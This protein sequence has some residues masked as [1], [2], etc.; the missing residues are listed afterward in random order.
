[1]ISL[2]N[3]SVHFGGKPLFEDVSFII[4]RRDRIGLTGLNGAGK[5]TLMRIIK[6]QMAP[7]T[8]QVSVPAASTI[9]YLPQELKLTSRKK[10]IDETVEAFAELKELEKKISH[11]NQVLGHPETG[12]LPGNSGLFGK[13]VEANE[14]YSML[15]GDTQYARAEKMLLGLGFERSGL[16]R[17]LSEFSGGW[18]MRVELAKILLQAPDLLMLDEP[19]NHLDIES[20]QWLE[21][22]LVDYPGAVMVVSH[23]RAFLDNVTTRTIE[24]SMGKVYDYK[25]CYS[26]YVMLR[27]E[28]LEQELA[29]HSNQQRQIAQIERFITR[30]RAKNTKAKQVQS[31]I[32]LLEK[33]EKVEVDEL[34]KSSIHFRFP[35]APPSGKVAVEATA[36]SKNYGQQVVL[37]DL[38]FSIAK[39]ERIA[40]VGRNGE[41]KT[42]LSRILIGELEHQGVIKLGHNVKVGYYAQNQAEYL[43]PDKTIFQTIDDVAVGEVRKQIRRIL[44][45]F[46]FSGDDIEKKVKVLS[47]GEKSRLA[48]ARL[49][50]EPV[51]LLVLDEPTNHLDMRSKDILKS[52]LLQF[53]GTV[54][55]VSHDRDFLQGLTNKVFE[56][57]N[58]KIKEF[59]GDVY[60][61]IQ[62]RKVASLNA[63]QGGQKSLINRKK[64]E[65]SDVR[66]TWEQ[67]KQ[68]ERD[69]KRLQNA[70]EKAE[71]EIAS[72]EKN[73]TDLE[74][75]MASPTIES[76]MIKSGE[77][78]AC[79]EETKNLI[80]KA[81]E[82]WLTLISKLES[83]EK[84]LRGCS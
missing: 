9:G 14:R 57:R 5:T 22:F 76:D 10:V 51:N 39:G 8:G 78:F 7:A 23:D 79:Y 17:P 40:F 32:K 47:G 77:I 81:E 30:F 26:D 58:Q 53:G 13:L 1:M 18:Q 33:M 43:D 83:I 84:D 75:I 45:G 48:I 35:E 19:T 29:A 34:D 61:F 42:T 21:N 66:E 55:I 62:Q 64:A 63:L 54:I 20:I 82:E 52:A 12:H 68:L 74:K 41:G 67:K 3:I 6:G 72:C 15:G 4:N 38:N 46:L 80:R 65:G 37:N 59:I 69:R 24:L 44:G 28:R 70:I 11:L 56:F 49:M 60:D 31:K 2:K 73:L 27:E 16:E 25:A 36:V 71:K 50:L